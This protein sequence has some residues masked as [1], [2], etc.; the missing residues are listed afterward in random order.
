MRTA[1]DA[2]YRISG[3]FDGLGAM[4]VEP[5]VPVELKLTMAGSVIEIVVG[6][7]VARFADGQS[8]AVRV[9][10]DQALVVRKYIFDFFD[11]GN[12][13]LWGWHGHSEPAGF[14]HRHDPP[15]FRARPAKSATFETVAA[16]ARRG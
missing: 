12:R 14:H 15:D 4:A 2:A 7:A 8:L 9:R 11:I 1:E 13:R 6:R 3:W 5:A 10:L 16:L